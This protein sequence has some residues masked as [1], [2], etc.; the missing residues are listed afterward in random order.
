MM[1][2]NYPLPQAEDISSI[3]WMFVADSLNFSFWEEDS[4]YSVELHGISY[5]GYMALCA[6]LT[7][8]L[9]VYLPNYLYLL[10]K[11]IYLLYSFMPY[12]MVSQSHLQSIM[13]TSLQKISPS[14]SEAV[15]AVVGYL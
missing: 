12:R 5:T 3:E 14:I 11:I 15:L 9:E 13:P 8:A 1:I 6:A 7:K 4:H 2:H 10:S